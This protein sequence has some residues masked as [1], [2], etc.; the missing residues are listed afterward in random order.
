M[1]IAYAPIA[2]DLPALD[3]IEMI[4]RTELTAIE[5]AHGDQLLEGG[6]HVA[7]LI[8]AAALEDRSLPVPP[9]GIAKTRV[10]D[11][12]DRLVQGSEMSALPAVGRNLDTLTLPRPDQASPVIS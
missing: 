4:N 11:R 10:A 9:P 1:D 8:L 12:E 6:L 2:R 5:A 7:R 3:G